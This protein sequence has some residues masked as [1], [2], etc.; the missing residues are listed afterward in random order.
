[1]HMVIIIFNL[2]QFPNHYHNLFQLPKNICGIPL[3]PNK[4]WWPPICLK[5][6]TYFYKEYIYFCKDIPWGLEFA[7]Q[8]EGMPQMH[9][10]GYINGYLNPNKGWWVHFALKK[11]ST[12]LW[13]TYTFLLRMYIGL[14]IDHKGGGMAQM[15][16]RGCTK[17]YLD[18]NKA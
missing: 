5:K 13:R 1:M 7:L 10:Q 15:N 4:A 2:Y 11:M 6:C 3:N 8:G 16:P 18:P 17:K 9:S 12:F 14:E